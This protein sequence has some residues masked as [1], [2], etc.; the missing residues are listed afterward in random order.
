MITTL[1]HSTPVIV[2]GITGRMCR[3]HAALMRGYG[4]NIVAGTATRGG[5]TTVYVSTS[6][7]YVYVTW[8]DG[9]LVYSLDNVVA[10]STDIDLKG[11]LTVV[12]ALT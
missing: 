3:T 12:K 6:M 7:A 2:Q 4:T 8:T 9:K 1:S 11:L 5:K 10:R